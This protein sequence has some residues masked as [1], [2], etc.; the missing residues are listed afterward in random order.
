MSVFGV[1][2]L[3]S[4]RRHSESTG[5][6]L[7]WVLHG[8]LGRVWLESRRVGYLDLDIR[9][10]W[11]LLL[12]VHLTVV[13]VGADIMISHFLISFQ[14]LRCAQICSFLTIFNQ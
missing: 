7:L 11:R 9:E 4:R 2:R 3:L 13:L 12:F 1:I 5:E 6:G 8:S 14:L 10:I